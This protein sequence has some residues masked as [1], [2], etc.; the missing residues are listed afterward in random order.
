[1]SLQIPESFWRKYSDRIEPSHLAT[2]KSRTRS[3]ES[4]FLSV[5]SVHE[6]FKVPIG[7][8]REM[9]DELAE[10]GYVTVEQH[11]PCPQCQKDLCSEDLERLRCECGQRLEGALPEVTR[12]YVLKGA[13]SRDVRWAVTVHGMNTAGVWQQDFSWRLAQLY[14]YAIPV[15]IY[16]YGNVKVAPFLA[17]LRRR[18]RKELL[19]YFRKVRAEMKA[20]GHG[21]RPDVIAHS[22]GTWL[23]AKMLVSD[24]SKDPIV[25]GRVIL[26]G[27]I[28]RPD[29]D[30]AQ[31]LEAGRVEAVL[32]HQAG[33][34]FPARLAHWFIRGTGPSS[35]RG[36]NDRQR[37]QHFLS[38]DFV[39]S[40]YFT[41]SHMAAVLMDQ[42]AP[43]LTQPGNSMNLP[44]EPTGSLPF[45]QWTPSLWRLITLTLPYVALLAILAF[46]ALVATAACLGL[47]VVLS[48]WPASL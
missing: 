46:L 42:W 32:C 8:A 2:L 14:G 33:R 22:F 31:L 10:S 21:G 44:A 1:M 9:L 3:R 34:D 35:V 43:F 26:T 5:E 29:F 47:P 18:H 41:E 12:T 23:L 25:L 36:F 39:H 7:L 40:D 15:G 37:V 38:P 13:M 48:H 6:E 28:I 16:K 11:Q 30:W 20:S 17:P 4:V 19:E 24:D 45:T 27:S